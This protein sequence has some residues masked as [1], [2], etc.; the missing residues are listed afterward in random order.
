M[1]ICM[2]RK[3]SLIR[4]NSFSRYMVDRRVWRIN[5]IFIHG[6]HTA[7][8]LFIF[9]V[10]HACHQ[11]HHCCV[12][13]CVPRPPQVHISLSETDTIWLL[14]MEGTSVAKDSEE[15]ET[16]QRQNELYR[17]V[18][19]TPIVHIVSVNKH[20]TLIRQRTLHSH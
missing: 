5:W 9:Y 8:M 14:D 1:Y 4:C 19:L 15:A 12:V 7:P 17:Q 6:V 10:V 11:H 18:R 20:S 13:H 3:Y 2:Y 16:V